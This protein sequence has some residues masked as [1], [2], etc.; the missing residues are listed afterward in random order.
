MFLYHIWSSYVVCTGI[1]VILKI[2]LGKMILFKQ[3]LSLSNYIFSI[4]SLTIIIFF[5][6]DRSSYENLYSK[7]FGAVVIYLIPHIVAQL[8]WVKRLNAHTGCTL[9]VLTAS[10]YI[11]FI[12]N[13]TSIY[14]L[15]YPGQDIPT[16]IN[17]PLYSLNILY[18]FMY[19]LTLA[20]ISYI[21]GKSKS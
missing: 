14:Y 21:S 12:R 5:L 8:F 15:P 13:E 9:L 6:I 7:I 11:H 2:F 19:I 1:L 16:H 4:V 17:L 10:I 3:Y 20:F 18:L